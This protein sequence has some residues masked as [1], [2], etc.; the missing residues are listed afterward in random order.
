LDTNEIVQKLTKPPFIF[1]L[2]G[3]VG[4]ALYK[5]SQN[6]VNIDD[7]YSS[8]SLN[9]GVYSA[10]DVNA[11]FDSS[12]NANVALSQ[13]ID[14]NTSGLSVLSEKLETTIFNLNDLVRQNNEDVQN[15]LSAIKNSVKALS[16]DGTNTSKVSSGTTKKSY[17][18]VGTWGKD[19]TSKTTLYG[20]A[21]NAGLSLKQILNLNPKYKSN[22]NLIY[23]GDKVRVA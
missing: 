22:P 2:I 12:Y 13:L 8:S 23:P 3:V 14:Q 17:V 16:I 9:T 20:I 15:S 6:N 21:E 7:G 1:I 5:A 4:F 18:T 11:M 19:P 10:E